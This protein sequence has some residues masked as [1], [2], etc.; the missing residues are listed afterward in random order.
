MQ[1]FREVFQPQPVKHPLDEQPLKEMVNILVFSCAKDCKWK[2][3]CTDTN[4]SDFM[5]TCDRYNR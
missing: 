4:K 5:N 3:I 2:K 1:V